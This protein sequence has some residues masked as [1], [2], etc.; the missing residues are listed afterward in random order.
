MS[1]TPEQ[2]EKLNAAIDKLAS[3]NICR[4]GRNVVREIV[5]TIIGEP[6]RSSAEVTHRVGDR[7]ANAQ[8]H[9]FILVS[10]APRMVVLISLHTGTRYCDTIPI[11]DI[12]R[13]PH[14]SGI[15]A[16][17]EDQFRKLPTP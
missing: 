1:T 9:E 16:G 10:P 15:F 2:K 8:G 12:T 13:V 14:K 5:E 4:E 6:L 11:E 7:F 3:L 17:N